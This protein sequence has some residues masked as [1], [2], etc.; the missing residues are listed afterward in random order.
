MKSYL[1]IYQI[2]GSES[3]YTSLIA[4]LK[5]APQWARP[6]PGVWVVKT[7]STAALLRDGVKSRIGPNDKVLVT[8]MPNSDWG[9]SNISKEVTDWM[10]NNL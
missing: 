6:I 4:Y 2:S 10:K 1:I 8:L 3:N 7:T 5:T 9:T